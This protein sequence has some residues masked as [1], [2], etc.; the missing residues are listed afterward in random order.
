MV[1][2]P[3]HQR[4]GEEG[5]R[6]RACEAPLAPDQ[7]YCL[8][9]GE[10]RAEARIPFMDVLGAEAPEP[11]RAVERR[12]DPVAGGGGLGGVPT[13][14]AIGIGVGM[15]IL[16]LSFGTVLGT[17]LAG[18][19]EGVPVAATGPSGPGQAA[20][21]VS[22]RGAFKSDW[23][24]GKDGYT[25]Q[26]QA[27]RK[28]GTNAQGVAD[29]KAAAAQKRAPDVGA[30]DSDDHKSLDP[31]NF[32]IFSGVFDSRGKAK[33]GLDAVKKEYPEAKVVRVSGRGGGGGGG[34]DEELRAEGDE[35]VSDE[36]L[37]AGKESAVVGRDQ[38][39]NIERISGNSRESAKL[40]KTI[41]IEGR[42]PPKD[43]KAPGGG[44]SGGGTTIGGG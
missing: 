25:V 22:D 16:L 17:M 39:D 29:A 41:G 18:N 6:C 21:E 32:V 14:L 9:C 5:E 8:N 44:D 27:L 42:P 3:G 30:L 4:L 35:K 26:L 28:E 43:N 1:E 19:R 23:P 20:Q 36:Y 13:P 40:P 38:L 2:T 7:R 33:A 34:G 24:E 10:R 37:T 15:V 31:G 11:P 12:S